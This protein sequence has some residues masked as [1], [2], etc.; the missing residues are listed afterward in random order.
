MKI[1]NETLT[2]DLENLQQK[3]S[4]VVIQYKQAVADY[5]A[6]TQTTSNELVSV[7][8]RAYAGTGTAGQSTATSLQTCQADC[9]ANKSCSGA[10]FVSN[11][12]VLRTGDTSLLPATPNSYA[13]V[14]KKKQLL[15]NMES[16]NAELISL[17]Q[18]IQDKIA[19]SESIFQ[20]NKQASVQSQQDLSNTYGALQEERT[21][22]NALLRDYEDLE[23]TE[24]ETDLKVTQRHYTYMLLS[25]VALFIIALLIV[26]FDSIYNVF[27]FGIQS[28]ENVLGKEAYFVLFWII[29]AIVIFSFQFQFFSVYPFTEFL[30]MVYRWFPTFQIQA[31]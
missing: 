15:L 2:M 20:A 4:N 18:Q 31:I 26:P 9:A 19:E 25:V 14:P 3:Q 28:K 7:Q 13:I 11:Q 8:G 24:I 22:I 17:N 5:L 29:L 27:D 12:C 21:A 30:H 10:T 23:A 6:Y 16:L 1:T